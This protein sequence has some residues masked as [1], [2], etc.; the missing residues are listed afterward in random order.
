M[1]KMPCWFPTLFGQLH[2]TFLRS[3]DFKK[4]DEKRA[5]RKGAKQEKKQQGKRTEKDKE[6]QGHLNLK[7]MTH[8][9]Y[10]KMLEDDKIY[11]PNF[12]HS[13]RSRNVEALKS[14]SHGCLML[15]PIPAKQT[16]NVNEDNLLLYC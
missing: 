10:K 9:A 15:W 12:F 16:K 14:L 13:L 2:A 8:I 5:K 11:G 3:L 4:R 1:H 7:R 6:E